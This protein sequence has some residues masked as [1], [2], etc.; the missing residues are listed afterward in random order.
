MLVTSLGITGPPPYLTVAISC[1]FFILY[2]ASNPP[3]G[4]FADK[5]LL[6]PTQAHSPSKAC[7]IILCVAAY[8]ASKPLYALNTTM[9]GHLLFVLSFTLMQ[10]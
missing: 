3:G 1:F 2:A 5:L 10:A 8:V 7:G 4:T 6:T 9:L